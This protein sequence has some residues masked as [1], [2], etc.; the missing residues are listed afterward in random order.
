MPKH[1]IRLNLQLPGLLKT[2]HAQCKGIRYGSVTMTI[3]FF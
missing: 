1:T 2:A 3:F